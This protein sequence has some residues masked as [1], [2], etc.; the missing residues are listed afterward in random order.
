MV[1]RSSKRRPPKAKGREVVSAES[2]SKLYD[3]G[4]YDRNQVSLSQINRLRDMLELEGLPRTCEL[5]GVCD[6]TLLRVTSGF[7]HKLRA[8]T[9]ARVRAF[10]GASK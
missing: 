1:A 9:A 2:I 3:I 4:P 8:D 5:V 6:V 10:F 7:A